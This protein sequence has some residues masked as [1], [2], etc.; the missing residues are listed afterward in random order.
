VRNFSKM[1]NIYHYILWVYV[2][3]ELQHIKV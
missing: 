2:N 1:L 3:L